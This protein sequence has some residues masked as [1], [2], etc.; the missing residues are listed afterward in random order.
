MKPAT[1][2]E[3]AKQALR[4]IKEL[5]LT[6]ESSAAALMARLTPRLEPPELKQRVEESNEAQALHSNPNVEQD[7]SSTCDQAGG[8]AAESA[9]F[10]LA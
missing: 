4:L 8:L 7:C 9:Y 1:P 6:R 2:G 5:K 3:T 10:T